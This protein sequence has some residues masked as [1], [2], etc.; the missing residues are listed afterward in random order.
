MRRVTLSRGRRLW[1]YAT[2]TLL[3]VSGAAWL[4]FQYWLTVA[5]DFGP[6]PHPSAPWWLRLH[7]AAAMVFLV[8]LGTLLRDHVRIGW[9]TRRNRPSGAGLLGFSIWLTLTGYS[10][11]YV[12]GETL[13]PW[14]TRLHWVPGLLWPL[15]LGWH[16]RLGRKQRLPH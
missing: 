1:I 10:L 13:R 4:I 14:L 7:G 6:S 2:V 11:Y 16:I 9:H 3:T 15:V 8:L 12:G 5:G